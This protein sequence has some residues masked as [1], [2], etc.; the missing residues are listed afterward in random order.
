MKKNIALLDASKEV[1][2][3][4]NTHTELKMSRLITRLQ[5]TTTMITKKGS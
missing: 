1:N 3:E 5:D 2:L 4:A